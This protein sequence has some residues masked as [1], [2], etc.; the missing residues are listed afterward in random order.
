ME[1][2]KA[3]RPREEPPRLTSPFPNRAAPGKIAA[4]GSART[5]G[6]EVGGTALAPALLPVPYLLRL[7]YPPP[8][9]YFFIFLFPPLPAGIQGLGE[10]L[11]EDSNPS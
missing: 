11:D 9:F 4:R 3:G 6:G 7:S 2:P 8:P 10:R 5:Q 1:H